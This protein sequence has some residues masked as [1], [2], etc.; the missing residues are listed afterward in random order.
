M[1]MLKYKNQLL[2]VLLSVLL[3]S[4]SGCNDKPFNERGTYNEEC[5]DGVVYYEN[6]KRLAPAF[7]QDGTLKLCDKKAN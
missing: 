7:N 5:L 2:A 1:Q 4:L 6:M 3:V